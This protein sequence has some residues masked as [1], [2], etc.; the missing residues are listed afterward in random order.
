M[1]C[2]WPASA[3]AFPR[4]LDIAQARHHPNGAE[5]VVRGNVTV[6]SGV[7]GSSNLDA[8]FVIQDSTGGIY[9]TTDRPLDLHLGETLEV[10]GMLT[11]DGHGQRM[12][13]LVQWHP[14]ERPLPPI[15]PK[16]A[17]AADAGKYLDGQLVTVQGTIVRPLKDDAPYGDRLWIADSTGE[18]Q[19]YLPKSTQIAPQALPFFQPGYTIQVTGFSSQFDDTDEVV[20]RS[21]AD[22]KVM[23]LVDSIHEP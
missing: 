13:S 15:A 17:S 7:F 12:L 4:T 22:I 16:M 9:V 1:V 14:C 10:D 18:I 5:V 6:P 2:V 20:P 8:G 11:D 21:R 19:I 3:I 23:E